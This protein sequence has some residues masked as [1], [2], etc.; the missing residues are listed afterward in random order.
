MPS[1]RDIL[2]AADAKNQRL[3]ITGALCHLNGEF[4]QYLEGPTFAVEDLFKLIAKDP[5]HT[6]VK[7]IERVKIETRYFSRWAMALVT[8]NDQTKAIFRAFTKSED[9][10]VHRLDEKSAADFFEA[11]ARSDNWHEVPKTST[12]AS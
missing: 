6:D 10:D 4:V 11:L 7:L 2:L 9:L 12:G 5:R 1:L 8:W 3:G